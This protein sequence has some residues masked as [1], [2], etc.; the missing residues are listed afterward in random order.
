MKKIARIA[1]ITIGSLVVLI[2][3]AALIIPV[4]FKDKIKDTVKSELDK[5][6]IAKV[7]FAD[8]KLSLIKAFPKAAFSLK[9]VSVTG[10]N[11][12]EGDTLASLN[13]FEIVFNLA[14]I[15]SDS[16][17]EVKSLIINKPFINALVNADGKANWDIMPVD[18]TA[19]EEV[20]ESS[21]PSSFKLQMKEFRITD[22]RINYIDKQADMN[23]SIQDLDFLLTGNMSATRTDLDMLLN[24]A[25]LSF[26]MEKVNYI[27]KAKVELKATIDALLDSMTFVMKDNYFKINDIMLAFSGK[28]AMPGDDIYTDL[29][30]NT[31]ETSFKS[32][33]SM[34]PAIYMEGFEE[35]RASG[36]FSLDGN[37]TGTYSE[38]DSTMPDAKITLL[39]ENGVISYP[40]LPEKISAIGIKTVVDFNGKDM[41]LTTVDVSKFHM[42]LASNP[43]DFSFHLA[44]PMSDPSFALKAV[45]KIDLAKLQDAVPLDSISLNGLIDMAMTM[46]GRMSMVEKEQYD[47]FT[48]E[49]KLNITSMAVEMVDMPAIKVN[50]ASF[51]FTPAYSELK[52]LNMMVGDKSDFNISGRLENYIPY[53]FS[54]GI[55]KGNLTLYS[56][57]IDANNIMEKMGTDTTT[58]VEDT[59]SLAVVVIPRNI[60]FTFNASVKELLYD[61]LQATNFKGNIVVA[62]G[63]VTLNNT[64]MDA[65]GGKIGMNAVYDTRDTL[66]PVVKADLALTSVGVKSAFNAFNT[67]QQL[68][69]AANGLDGNI[70]VNLKYESLLG[71]DMMPVISSITGQGILKSDQLQILESK[72]FDRMKSVVKLSDK[73]SNTIKNINASFTIKDGRVYVKPFDTR[74]GNIKLNIAGDQGLDKTLNWI[75]KTEIPRSDLGDGANA[76]VSSLTSQAASYGL[77]IKPSDVIK[78]NLNVGGTFTDPTVKPLFGDGSGSA[79]SSVAGSV[80]SAVK[81]QASEK[82]NEAAKEQSEK[83]LKEAEEQAQKIRDEAADAAKRIRDEA[84]T[85]GAKLIKEAESKGPIAVAA[86]K[87]AAARL[88]TEADKK[89]TALETEANAKADKLLEEAKAKSDDML[90]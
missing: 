9:E 19:T 31:S 7:D 3:A 36:T 83:I 20:T 75:V 86:A 69:P 68:A 25:S 45:G 72:A 11:E 32:L 27:S 37:L 26:G 66:K 34:V 67:I 57:M 74:L 46:S 47:K 88:K 41:D 71:S 8:Y 90:K 38:A 79:S 29:K 70:S 82:V 1:G 63:V 42:E 56:S 43:F 13:S 52:K 12:F 87:K 84:D 53:I 60:D 44:T 2:L 40:D 89:A 48:A 18:T 64:G 23:A 24:I 6:L 5:M 51:I 22:A 39:V 28:V 73:Y 76:L 54:D 21:E 85:Q 65:L 30:F 80:T 16:G 62:D 81:E 61:N 50:E 33:L 17:Y 10:K 35:L 15:F 49:G 59:T 58:V 77:T 78:V 55:I 14:S 4:L